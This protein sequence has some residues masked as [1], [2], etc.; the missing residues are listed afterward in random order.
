VPFVPDSQLSA[1]LTAAGVTGEAATAVME[2]NTA[3]RLAGLRASLGVL[4]ILGL[5]AVY[6]VNGIPTRQPGSAPD[7]SRAA[8]GAGP[9][10]DAAHPGDAAAAP[11]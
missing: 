8:A 9:D 3:A 2:E 10:P 4:A 5:I 6:S 1:A 7:A 11:G